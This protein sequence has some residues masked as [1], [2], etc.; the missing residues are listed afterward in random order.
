MNSGSSVA[1]NAAIARLQPSTAAVTACAI[2][3][4]G[5][6]AGRSPG[7]ASGFVAGSVGSPR[8]IRAMVPAGHCST[9]SS[10]A[11][12]RSRGQLRPFSNAMSAPALMIPSAAKLRWLMSSSR[13]RAAAAAPARTT[14][15]S[16]ATGAALCAGSSDRS[17]DGCTRPCC[18]AESDGLTTSNVNALPPGGSPNRIRVLSLTVTELPRRPP[19]NI[20]L[21]MLPTIRHRPSSD[22]AR[23]CV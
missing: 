3:D 10:F 21:G 17:A 4:A 8:R 7:D 14:P 1:G 15:G 2:K 9:S 5:P 18:A 6:S 11:R 23:R 13:R 19:T 22:T 12:V 20:P 16:G